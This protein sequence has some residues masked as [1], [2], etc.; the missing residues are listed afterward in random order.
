MFN[1]D[2]IFTKI[3][4][5]LKIGVVMVFAF[6]IASF[7]NANVFR[8]NTPKV[9]TDAFQF[10]AYNFDNTKNKILSFF[11]NKRYSSPEEIEKAPAIPLGKG[12]YARENDEV[13]ATEIRIDETV[14]TEYTVTIKGKQYK[15]KVAQGE[16]R[17]SQE[18]LEQHFTNGN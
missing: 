4:S 5:Y 7:L 3:K 15:I 2:Y 18:V 13:K 11:S 12:V 14:W 1:R 17:P 6:F 9:R 10:T 8:S 16:E